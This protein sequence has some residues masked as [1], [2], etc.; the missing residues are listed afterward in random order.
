M[1]TF[2]FATGI[3][4][5]YPTIAGGER[6]D[7]MLKCGHYDR[8]RDDLRLTRELGIDNLRI[9]PAYYIIHEAPGRYRWELF[10]EVVSEMQ[11]LRIEPIIDLLHFGVPDWLGNFQNPEFPHYFAEYAGAFAARY[12]HV[13]FYTPVNEI[14][15]TAR[16]SAR[17][18]WW[19]ERLTGD[20][21]FVTALKHLTRANLLAM[22]AIERVR[23]EAVFVQAES[24]EY[25][26]AG[27]PSVVEAAEMENQLRFLPLD[28]T[29]GVEPEP[30]AVDYLLGN[31]MTQA[32]LDFL[33][34][35]ASTE[36]RVIGIDYYISSEHVL[37]PGGAEAPPSDTLGL[38]EIC[39]DYYGRYGLPMMHTETN[40]GADRAVDWMRK[41]WMGVLRLIE[42]GVPIVGFTWFSLVDQMDWDTA[43]R[44]NNGRVSTIGLVDMARNL[45]PVGEYYR[46]LIASWKD[47]MPYG[48]MAA[49]QENVER[50]GST[51]T[52][53]A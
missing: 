38:V 24:F 41:Q 4:N 2:L 34:P 7:E 20:R 26:H 10:D 53:D 33:A 43:L 17:Y 23:P 28:L 46:T 22:Q 47:R 19:N 31:G 12:P 36:R 40:I 37:L 27:D 15:I 44:E 49:A 3:E 50:V 6:V 25:W 51:E 8:W 18:G 32:E 14:L 52:V 21:P 30:A 35:L 42:T 9:G 29:Y 13:R 48:E 16:F 11:R 45:R 1:S 5:S 39:R